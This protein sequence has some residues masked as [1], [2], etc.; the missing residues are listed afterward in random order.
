MEYYVITHHKGGFAVGEVRNKL[1]SSNWVDV[2]IIIPFTGSNQAMR[3]YYCNGRQFQTPYKN[4][5]NCVYSTFF[6]FKET[7][8]EHFL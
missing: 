2:E 1:R 7:H 3:T 6:C 4:S 5:D 8:P